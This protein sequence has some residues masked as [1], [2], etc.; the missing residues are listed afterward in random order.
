MDSCDIFLQIF[1]K[2]SKI[3]LKFLTKTID[4]TF[5]STE[6]MKGRQPE[7]LQ[8]LFEML[9]AIWYHLYNWKN[10]K[11]TRGGVLR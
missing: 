2:L 9:C 4:Q 5:F 11:N 10:L 3:E 7:N 1:F 8:W 6:E